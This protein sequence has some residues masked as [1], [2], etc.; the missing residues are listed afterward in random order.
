TMIVVY[1]ICCIIIFF[2]LLYNCLYDSK[3]K[4]R[5]QFISEIGL[6]RKQ[7]N[8]LYCFLKE[9]SYYVKVIYK[10]CNLNPEARESQINMIKKWYK[11]DDE[12]VVNFIDNGF[13]MSDYQL[14]DGHFVLKEIS[15][16]KKFVDRMFQLAFVMDGIHNDEWNLLMNI[17]KQL[18]FNDNYIDYFQKRYGPLRTEFEADEQ[19]EKQST[20]NIPVSQL[21]AYFAILGLE[22]GASDVEIKKAYHNLALQHHPDL[23]K[24]AN[25]VSE[26]EELMARINEAYEKIRN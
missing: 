17:M 8:N 10:I 14:Y 11:F 15:Q 18:N 3:Y 9:E 26:C 16:K 12:S 21:K 19:G 6:S 25:R 20:K 1:W 13:K 24:N 4:E 22:E 2:V 23:P 5:K 7:A